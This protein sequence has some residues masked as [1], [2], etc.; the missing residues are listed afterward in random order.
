MVADATGGSYESY[1]SLDEARDDR[2]AVVVLEGDYGGQIYATIPVRD[3]R[4]S[5][6]AL[7]RLLAGLDAIAWPGTPPRHE[8]P[9][10]RTT[11]HR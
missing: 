5:M 2:D 7:E 1:R 8:T 9:L 11:T 4:C 6:N 10:F 3:I